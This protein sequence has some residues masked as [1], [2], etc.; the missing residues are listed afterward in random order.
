MQGI[1]P[2]NKYLYSKIY[3]EKKIIEIYYGLQLLKI[4]SLENK[5]LIY[6]EAVTY[7]SSGMRKSEIARA[8]GFDYS[9]V[10]KLTKIYEREGCEGILNLK[11]G[12][13]TKVTEEI[14]RFIVKRFE[15]YYEM[16]G[17]KNF[18]DNIIEDVV[19]EYDVHI[20]YETLRMTIKPYKERIRQGETKSREQMEQNSYEESKDKLPEKQGKSYN[21]YSGLLLLNTFIKEIPIFQNFKNIT[22][23]N[24]IITNIV[25]LLIY[26]LFLTK[27]KIENYKELNHRELS[28]II[29]TEYFTYPEDVRRILREHLDLND[30]METNKLMFKYYIAKEENKERW[31]FIDGHV[32][33]YYGRHK[34]PKGYH[35]QSNSAVPGRAHYFMHTSDGRPIYFEIND[36]YNDFREMINKLIGEMKEIVGEKEYKKYLFVFDRGGYSFDEFRYLKDEEKVNF[37]TWAKNDRTDY[38]KLDL[39]YEEVEIEL[40]GNH[41]DKPVKK[42][43]YVAIIN[44]NY[45]IKNPNRKEE[46]VELRKIVIRNGKKHTSFLT[47]DYSRSLGELAKALYFRWREE[48]SFEVEVKYRGLNDINSY[49]V[50]NFSEDVI[51]KLGYEDSGTKYIESDEYKKYS[52]ERR[53]LKL[54]I[55][56]QQQKLGKLVEEKKSLEKIKDNK[57]YKNA[58][59]E[60]IKLKKSLAANNERIKTSN[61]KI[62]KIDALI[63]NRI[64]RL[65]YTQKFF[66]DIIRVAC[67]HID[68]NIMKVLSRFYKNGRDIFKMIDIILATGGCIEK[69]DSGN[70]VVMLNQLNTKKENKVLK[71]FIEYVNSQNPTFLIDESQQ[72]LFD[73]Q[74]H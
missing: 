1:L 34:I 17:G 33:R 72:V 32:L 69:D 61:E 67:S 35:Q 18:R 37:A 29:S 44:D 19:D 13:I 49:R 64:K 15:Y 26:M 45:K 58:I 2:F 12:P 27:T 68:S 47:N 6:L 10:Y 53:E 16:Q 65:D 14:E 54:E 73:L 36:F 8:F 59:A 74:S 3:P 62:K 55:K 24:N 5:P 46:F 71:S 52:K 31:I 23:K 66:I 38:K 56:K 48:K 11:R 30:L 9:W 20:S 43:F 25:T 40:K 42:K 4:L 41:I 57:K 50:E 7:I 51:K 39:E 60:I 28:M 22:N 63:S 70:Y 21:R